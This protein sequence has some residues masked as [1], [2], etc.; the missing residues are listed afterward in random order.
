MEPLLLAGQ[1]DLATPTLRDSY[2]YANGYVATPDAID[3]HYELVNFVLAP[4]AARTFV[5]SSVLDTLPRNNPFIDLKYALL[6]INSRTA[7][8]YATVSPGVTHGFTG[9]VPSYPGAG[10]TPSIFFI[11]YWPSM[12]GAKSLCQVICGKRNSG[13]IIIHICKASKENAGRLNF[14]NKNNM[15]I[16]ISK[17]PK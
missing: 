10:V 16:S 7:G 3:D 15:P 6:L 11:M 13:E 9:W 2:R 17:I 8:D 12:L 4:S 5:L 1:T 14:G